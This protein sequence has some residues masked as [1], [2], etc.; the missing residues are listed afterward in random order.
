MSF[1]RDRLVKDWLY[2]ATIQMQSKLAALLGNL[3]LLSG[4]MASTSESTSAVSEAHV[5]MPDHMRR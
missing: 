3:E 2:R 4:N 5:N 1:G